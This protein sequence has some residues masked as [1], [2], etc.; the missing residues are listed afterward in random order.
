MLQKEKLMKVVRED[1]TRSIYAIQPGDE[2]MLGGVAGGD[3]YCETQ[4]RLITFVSG[5]REIE[6][7]IPEELWPVFLGLVC[8][9]YGKA[10]FTRKGTE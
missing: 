10:N 6:I 7:A 8:A 2:V 5:A 4:A 9:G 1:L 3:G